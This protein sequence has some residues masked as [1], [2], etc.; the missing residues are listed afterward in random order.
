MNDSEEEIRVFIA[1]DNHIGYLEKDPIRGEDSFHVFE[2]I[3]LLAKSK[4][5][6]FLL[7]GGDLF[8]VNQPSRSCM[9]KTINMFRKHCFSNKPTKLEYLS[10][11]KVNF[12]TS[13]NVVNYKD[14]SIRVS[15]PVFTIHGNHDDPSGEGGLSAVDILSDSGLVNYFGKTASVD[16][17]VIE[18]VLLKK[19]DN[20]VAIYG[21]GSIRDERL[22]RTM[23]NKRVTM[24]RPKEFRDEWFN[25]M[26]LES[27]FD[28]VLWGHEHECLITPEPNQIKKFYV[29]QPGSSVATS[30]SEGETVE[31]YVGLMRIKGKQF[32]LEKI[33]LQNVR[34][35]VM[36]TVFLNQVPELKRFST[37]EKITEYLSKLVNQLVKEAKTKYAEQL[38]ESNDSNIENKLGE[39]PKPLIRVR[40]DYAGG[41]EPFF[42][43][44]FGLNFVDVVANPREIIHF[45]KRQT[46][47][48]V[49]IETINEKTENHQRSGNI[50]GGNK[51]GQMVGSFIQTQGLGILTD[52]ELN[53][54]LNSVQ[55]IR[56]EKMIELYG[57]TSKGSNENDKSKNDGDRESNSEEEQSKM[58][59]N[60]SE[61]SEVDSKPTKV[62]KSSTKKVSGW[63]TSINK[64]G[65][66]SEE[67]YE[68]DAKTNNL[69]NEYMN[70]SSIDYVKMEE[71][72][73]DD[74]DF[75][76]VI[77]PGDEKAKKTTRGSGTTRGRKAATAT[78]KPTSTR[79][80]KRLL[81]QELSEPEEKKSSDEEQDIKPQKENK[82]VK[83]TVET[84]GKQG[85]LGSYFSRTKNNDSVEVKVEKPKMKADQHESSSEDENL[86]K[87][88][89]NITKTKEPVEKNKKGQ[90][91]KRVLS[92]DRSRNSVETRKTKVNYEQ[93]IVIGESSSES[94][95]VEK[96]KNTRGKQQRIT[97][98][99]KPKGKTSVAINGG[100]SD[101][102]AYTS[103]EEK[104][105]YW[106]LPK[107]PH[108]ELNPQSEE[109]SE[110]EV[111]ISQHTQDKTKPRG[112]N[113]RA[114]TKK[115]KVIDINS[116]TNYEDEEVSSFAKFSKSKFTR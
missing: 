52:I 12:S 95:M 100:T 70:N 5:A 19:N 67:D 6:D 2:E 57:D 14:P 92:T 45:Y 23:A 31:K 111:E 96:T 90:T 11:P 76:K 3:L 113:K 69:K 50:S 40:V 85:T 105:G 1:T 89:Q 61:E 21:L 55:K 97:T 78:K 66:D 59:K 102:E 74:G 82:K 42:P 41:F 56:K 8:H 93:T 35:F 98:N 106:N 112:G 71:P 101:P 15:L 73:S 110:Y 81:S 24:K 7:L 43:H 17:I 9:S 99:K 87:L 62:T 32:K 88:G 48:L 39:D 29:I 20:R 68:F 91:N 25:I 33:R 116:E 83:S 103:E 65:T 75:D 77:F 36:S 109:E 80:I 34:P 53:E 79:T 49:D 16:E 51:V 86:K 84:K 108:V 72:D 38:E 58:A 22:F 60:D 18:P 104:S 64:Q 63:I 26:F 107:G 4:N 46:K 114:R 10:D 28:V 115:T 27:F 37:E 94:E 13:F 47:N 30:L 54:A 44:R